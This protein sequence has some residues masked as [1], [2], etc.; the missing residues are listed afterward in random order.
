MLDVLSDSLNENLKPMINPFIKFYFID[1]HAVDT[2]KSD[3]MKKT[4]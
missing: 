3:Y 2:C 1:I 4:L